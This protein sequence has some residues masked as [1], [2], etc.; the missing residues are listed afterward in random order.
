MRSPSPTQAPRPGFQCQEGSKSYNFWLK[1][2]AT[3]ELWEKLLEPQAVP[4]KEPPH[5]LTPFELQHQGSNL[6]GTSG[7]QGETKVSGIKVSRGHCPFSKP[8]PAEPASW[9]HIRDSVNMANT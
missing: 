4:L 9:C 2:L 1:K 3:I 7:I 8:F 5:R 6:E